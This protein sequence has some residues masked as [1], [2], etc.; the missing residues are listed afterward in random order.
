MSKKPKP[1][2]AATTR[3]SRASSFLTL[4][5]LISS[6][7]PLCRRFQ[8]MKNLCGLHYEIGKRRQGFV[9]MVTRSAIELKTGTSDRRQ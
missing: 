7:E 3:S 9:V 8:E 6:R 1:Y 2:Y 4:L 5:L